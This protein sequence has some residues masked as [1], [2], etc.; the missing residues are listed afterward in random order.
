MCLDMYQLVFK[1]VTGGLKVAT[2]GG[3]DWKG[4]VKH[5]TLQSPEHRLSGVVL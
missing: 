3:P 5:C 2:Y 4:L 1:P